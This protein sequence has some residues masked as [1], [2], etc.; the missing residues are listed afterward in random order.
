MR[1]HD[2]GTAA[3][4]FALIM[5]LLVLLIFAIVDLGRML[6]AQIVLTE[7]A[8]EGARAT[9]LGNDPQTH[10]DAALGGMAATA[11]IVDCTDPTG[12]ASVTLTHAFTFLLLGDAGVTLTGHAAM[13][14]LH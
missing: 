2:R 11:A 14:C 1:S 5:P 3:V 9:A 8:R 4:E 13:A 7:A 6:N 12:D 10:I